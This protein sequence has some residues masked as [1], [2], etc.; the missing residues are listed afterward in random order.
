MNDVF[1]QIGFSPEMIIKTRCNRI[2]QMSVEPKRF[3]QGDQADD[4]KTNMMVRRSLS[5]GP[6]YEFRQKIGLRFK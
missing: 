1:R 3:K 6:A 2:D 5:C 4:R